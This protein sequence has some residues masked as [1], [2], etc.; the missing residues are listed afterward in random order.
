VYY[1]LGQWK[2]AADT[3]QA[4]A[5]TNPEGPSGYDLFFLAMA[6]RQTG[7]PAKAKDCY[8][9]AVR[10]CRAHGKLAHHQLAELLAIRAEAEG[11]LHRAAKAEITT[12]AAPQ[13]GVLEKLAERAASD[14][15][16]QAELARHFAERGNAPLAE[17]ARIKA[18]RLFEEALA[19]EPENSIWAA[20]LAEVLLIASPG[21]SGDPAIFARERDRFFAAKLTD[22]WAKLAA[23]YHILGDQ[24][25]LDSLLKRHREAA[26]GIADVYQSAGRTREAIPH[27]AKASA[28]NPNDTLLSLKV[29][30]LQAWFGQ[31]KELAATRQQILSFAKDTKDWMVAERAAKVC[32]LLP[33]IDR[34]EREAALA[35]GRK[36]VE[37]G[38]GEQ[39]GEWASLTLGMTEY[40]C[41]NDAAAVDALL[42]AAKAGSH[43]PYITDTAAFYRAMSLFRQGKKDEARRL[44]IESAAQMKPLA[45]DEQN[46]LPNNAYPWEG[47]W[48]DELILW[49]AYKEAKAM[50][51][52]DAPAAA[53]VQTKAK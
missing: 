33:S 27:L 30:A 10:W 5:Q 46:P 11:L 6:Y 20:E 40:R 22:P 43:N 51:H 36:A 37:L 42:A 26:S 28:A 53:P 1:R 35:L 17:A 15:Q 2:E 8:D 13:E 39:W 3:L 47:D 25:A 50:I 23:A 31:G 44:A 45:K 14:A 34:A 24:Q 16:F 12:A 4:S 41:G 9:Q 18:R 48:Q 38:Q 29:A 52:F 32:S 21:Q 49:L 19:K 7:Q